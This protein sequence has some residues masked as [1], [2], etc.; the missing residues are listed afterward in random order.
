VN[1]PI[2]LHKFKNLN[3]DISNCHNSC[4]RLNQIIK[5]LLMFFH[6]FSI[7][8]SNQEKG[9]RKGQKIG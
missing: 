2:S 3:F 1:H 6:L 9:I 8:A 5:K 7:H 4:I